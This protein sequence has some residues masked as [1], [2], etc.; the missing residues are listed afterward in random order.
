VWFYQG[1]LVGALLAGTL[2][3][4]SYFVRSGGWGSLLGRTGLD[5]SIGFPMRL[6]SSD[7]LHFYA[8]SGRGLV[9]DAACALGLSMLCGWVAL[10]SASPLNRLVGKLEVVEADENQFQFSIRGLLVLTLVGG[11]VSALVRS[12]SWS[13]GVLGGIYLLGPLCLVLI[14]MVPRRIGW[15]Q[16]LAIVT[17]GALI[18]I[19][20]AIAVGLAL[21]IQF[22]KVLL[23]IFACWTPQSA[24]AAIIL[25]ADILYQRRADM[26]AT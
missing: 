13:P 20:V 14:A 23:G 16:R 11:V 22:D 9:V 24:L 3:A 7:G 25:M 2:N 12:F 5:E 19:G 6:W 4:L 10:K 17:P 8:V 18:L 21:Q 26:A 1:A 15:H